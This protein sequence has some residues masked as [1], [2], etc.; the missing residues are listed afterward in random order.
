M[1][2]LLPRR[3]FV[4]LA[5]L[6]AL[7]GRNGTAAAAVLPSPDGALEALLP[8]TDDAAVVGRA[9]LAQYATEADAGLLRRRLVSLTA[10]PRRLRAAIG[11]RI[12]RDF[13][14]GDTV[15]IEGW[16]LS[17]TEARLCALCA[18]SKD[19]G[20]PVALGASAP[21]AGVG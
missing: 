14:E 20:T 1:M 11:E 16:V 9:Y 3:W 2:P 8:R 5:T 17:R 19:R 4:G 7:F 21:K 15:R 12:R 13:A 6:F 10:E 18:L